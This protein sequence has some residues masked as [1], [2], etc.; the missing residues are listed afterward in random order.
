MSLTDETTLVSKNK[1]DICVIVQ[2]RLSSQRCRE[3]MIR[4]FANDTLTGLILKKLKRSTTIPMDNIYLSVHEPELVQIGKENGINIFNRSQESAVWDGGAGTHITGM[5]EWW[6]KLPYKYA[7]LIN[8]C[9]PMM[10]IKTI[11]N[12]YESYL[13]SQS[14][15]MFAVIK[16]KNY[17]WNKKGKLIVPWPQGEPC[18]NTKAVD[19]TLEAAHCLYAGKMSLIGQGVWMGDFNNGEIDLVTMPEEETFDIDYEWE[20]SLYEKL[21]EALVK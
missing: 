9:A 13:N 19:E 6:N 3:K 4:P 1:D 2:A 8:A 5:Y 18:M 7:I 17:F 14:D 16:K 20:F 21:Y 12:F 10:T 15:G 11:D